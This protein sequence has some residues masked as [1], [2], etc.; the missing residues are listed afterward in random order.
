M[1]A[2]NAHYTLKAEAAEHMAKGWDAESRAVLCDALKTRAEQDT[3]FCA[4]ID[5]RDTWAQRGRE[6]R[7]LA[8][9]LRDKVRG[10]AGVA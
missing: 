3:A 5:Q 2:L 9:S 4:A 6:F 7:Q 8:A 10:K 1:D